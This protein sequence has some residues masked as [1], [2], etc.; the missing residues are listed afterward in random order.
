ARRACDWDT[1]ERAVGQARNIARVTGAGWLDR[2]ALSAQRGTSGLAGRLSGR[3]VGAFTRREKAVADLLAVGL[4]NAEIAGRL[5]LTVKTVETHLTRIYR[6]LGVRS[7]GAA[8]AM[9]ARTT[10]TAQA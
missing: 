5:Y 8:T 3:Q 9:L 1:A 7:R 6:K 2:V 4:S 10:P